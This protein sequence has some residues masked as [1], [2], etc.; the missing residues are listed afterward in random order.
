MKDKIQT[1]KWRGTSER[2]KNY[3]KCLCVV[4]YR[5]KLQPMLLQYI[6]PGRWIAPKIWLN[7]FE[8]AKKWIPISEI[9]DLLNAN[10]EERL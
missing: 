9:V 2:P 5:G 6:E 4:N 8:A 10:E 3:C 7:C 1:I